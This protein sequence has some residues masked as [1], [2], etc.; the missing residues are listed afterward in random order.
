MSDTIA[1]LQSVVWVG[2]LRRHNEAVLE[3][4]ETCI[5]RSVID[6]LLVGG[7]I[8]YTVL[9][10]CVGGIQ[11][12]KNT[13]GFKIKRSTS[14]IFFVF[15]WPAFAELFKNLCCFPENRV[16]PSVYGLP[17]FSGVL[18]VMFHCTAAC[19]AGM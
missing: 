8:S 14:Y 10:V 7:V 4:F 11:L 6:G 2:R 9:A 12:E 15:L 1:K 3:S 17:G 5:D 13:S 16:Q 18:K 19:L